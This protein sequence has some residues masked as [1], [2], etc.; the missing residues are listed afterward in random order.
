LEEQVGTDNFDCGERL[1]AMNA[2]AVAALR[3]SVRT[4]WPP[5]PVT[6]YEMPACGVRRSYTWSCPANTRS[7]PWRTRLGSSKTRSSSAGP[8]FT[9]SEYSGWWK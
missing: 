7:T 1:F 8:C 3:R 5:A 6:K 2:A 9:P 4:S